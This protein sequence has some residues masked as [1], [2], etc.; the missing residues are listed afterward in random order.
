[1]ASTN[2]ATGPTQTYEDLEDTKVDAMR[3]MF[4]LFEYVCPPFNRYRMYVQLLLLIIHS[5]LTLF[6]PHFTLLT[7]LLFV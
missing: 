1:M 7:R 6:T 4:S 5:E 3:E 2:M